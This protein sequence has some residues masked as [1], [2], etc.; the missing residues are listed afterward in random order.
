MFSIDIYE[1][2]NWEHE[3]P[4]I[5]VNLQTN[6]IISG[7]NHLQL[8]NLSIKNSLSEPIVMVNVIS[9]YCCSKTIW[10][11]IGLTFNMIDPNVLSSWLF[12]FCLTTLPF[13]APLY[14]TYLTASSTLLLVW[15]E[16]AS[17]RFR[18]K[19]SLYS[20]WRAMNVPPITINST[21]STLWPSCFNWNIDVDWS[22]HASFK[23]LTHISI[24]LTIM[25]LRIQTSTPTHPHKFI[26]NN[27]KYSFSPLWG[28]YKH[29]FEEQPQQ[30]NAEGVKNT[31]TEKAFE[32]FV[33]GWKPLIVLICSPTMIQFSAIMFITC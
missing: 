18:I 25:L 15:P 4:K 5:C 12:P 14:L 7:F 22:N 26:S 20:S 3:M 33:T 30:S 17:W 24:L 10:I 2:A 11:Q 29:P 13:W 31:C 8:G 27:Y 16:R 9:T 28:Y 6:L 32:A 1:G 21:L 23:P 19:K